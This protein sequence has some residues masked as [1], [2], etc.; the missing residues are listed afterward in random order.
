MNKR[1]KISSSAATRL[2]A[3]DTRKCEEPSKKTAHYHRI[4]SLKTEKGNFNKIIFL[5]VISRALNWHRVDRAWS[6]KLASTLE[7]TA[8]SEI[9]ARL[10]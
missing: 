6:M 10:L 2:A 9:S 1:N 7:L 5:I 3:L 4:A 8:P